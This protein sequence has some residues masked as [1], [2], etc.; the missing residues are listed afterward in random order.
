MKKHEL[1]DLCL[2][3]VSRVK[4]LDSYH[5]I[6]L[7][8]MLLRKIR[9]PEERL[10]EI[11]RKVNKK[12]ESRYSVNESDEDEE[13]LMREA[14]RIAVCKSAG[15]YG[16]TNILIRTDEKSLEQLEAAIESSSIPKEWVLRGYTVKNVLNYMIDEIP[17]FTKIAQ[18]KGLDRKTIKFIAAMVFRKG[19]HNEIDFRQN[20]WETLK[21]FHLVRE[22]TEDINEEEV[23]KRINVLN[24]ILTLKYVKI[25]QK[26]NLKEDYLLYDVFEFLIQ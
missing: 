8:S 9:H 13:E 14:S 3:E 1:Y 25:P 24:S 10:K 22:E 18:I 5:T 26:W 7:A 2:L 19:Y 21:E 16:K 4:R 6:F 15:N 20:I 23:D 17:V 11:T 12:M